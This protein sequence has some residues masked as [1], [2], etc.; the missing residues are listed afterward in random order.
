MPT[1]CKVPPIA[2]FNLYKGLAPP[3]WG[4]QSSFG[5]SPSAVGENSNDFGFWKEIA[6]FSRVRP[7]I[8]GRSGIAET[9]IE[10]PRSLA[11]AGSCQPVPTEADSASFRCLSG[12]AGS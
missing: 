10:N 4:E 2:I 8:V 6:A 11:G 3:W 12:N 9:V 5:F 1:A 7:Q